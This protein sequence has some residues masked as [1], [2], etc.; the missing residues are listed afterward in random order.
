M[1]H[2][3]VQHETLKRVDSKRNDFFFFKE[4]RISPSCP[5][6]SRNSFVIRPKP[7]QTWRN[8]SHP[9]A[10]IDA[11]VR[12]RILDFNIPY[13]FSFPSHQ[14]IPAMAPI[15]HHCYCYCLTPP[16]CLEHFPYHQVNVASSVRSMIPMYPRQTDYRVPRRRNQRHP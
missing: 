13:R 15:N 9:V 12:I 16:S 6:T 10:S 8:G 14:Y 2:Y 7:N 1:P 5:S 4:D 11:N 3:V